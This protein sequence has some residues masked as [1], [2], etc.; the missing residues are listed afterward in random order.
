MAEL[1]GEGIVAG[2][3]QP[4]WK[5]RLAAMQELLTAVQGSPDLDDAR[6]S[7]LMQAVAFIPGWNEK[8]FQVTSFVGL[9]G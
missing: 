9:S 7:M 3:Q 6:A 5:E 8:N 1:F 4:G 2:L